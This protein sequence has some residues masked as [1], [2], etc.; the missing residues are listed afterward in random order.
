M[1]LSP[2]HSSSSAAAEAEPGL[3]LDAATAARFAKLPLRC[4]RKEYPNKLDHV[5]AGPHEVQSPRALHPAFYG[6]YDWHSCVHGHWMMVRLL[7]EFPQMEGAAEI[8]AV[9]DE[10][11]AT[12]MIAA[13]LVYF[14]QAN[15][16]T[17]ERTYGWAWLLKLQAELRGWESPEAARWAASVQP[18]ADAVVKAFTAFLPLQTYPIRTGVHPNTAFGLSLARDYALAVKDSSLEA[19]IAE[20]ARTYYLRDRLAPIGWEPGGEDF[21]S[22]A[23]EEA[24]LMARILPAKEFKRWLQAFLPDLIKGGAKGKLEPAHVS[25]RT[26]REELYVTSVNGEFPEQITH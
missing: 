15:R 6:C 4:V 9:L 21:L 3:S 19:L 22:P 14:G 8:R 16:K 20:R 23:L 10:N 13:E 25:D 26:D 2:S 1:I 12:T 5:M 17:F 11:L 24:S 18:L 7:R